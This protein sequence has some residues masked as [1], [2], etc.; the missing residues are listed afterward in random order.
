MNAVGI[1]VYAGG[2][3]L[4]VKKY[5][6]VIA[7]MEDSK[8]YGLEVIGNNPKYFANTRIF[9]RADFGWPIILD[10]E[11]DF[12]FANP[13]CAPFSNN[14]PISYEKDSWK[15]DPRIQ[16]WSN[17]VEY[18][19]KSRAKVVAIETVPQAY[20]KA[21]ELIKDTLNAMCKFYKYAYLYF[22][23]TALIGSLQN[24][25]RLFIIGSN[26]LIP[27]AIH[28]FKLPTQTLKDKL[29][30]VKEPGWSYPINPRYAEIT[31]NSLPGESL[32]ETFDRMGCTIE[33]N[34]KGQV[35]GRPS[36]NV[37]R[38]HLDERVNT[39]CGFAHVH[40]T[41]NRHISV[42]EYQVL[43]DFPEDYI[44]P[45]KG[46]SYG[47]IAR[48]VSPLAGEHL[49]RLVKTAID[50]NKYDQDGGLVV[51]SGIAHGEKPIW[52]KVDINQLPKLQLSRRY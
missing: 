47:Y 35:K 37:K 14:N 52:H 27:L 19:I 7:H 6:D 31:K 51:F 32:R 11:I 49:A 2:F 10:K 5:F 34:D 41:E 44:F 23:N 42:K 45:D 12:V 30:T 8:P 21:E 9:P 13:P 29:F 50:Y 18:A 46:E 33:L 1:Y 17:V 40:P 48:G 22:H 15:N 28:N 36:F 16:C 38:L 24:R 39:L 20:T 43:A 3:S 4:G 25:N 26:V